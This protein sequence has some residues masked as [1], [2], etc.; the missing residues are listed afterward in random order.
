MEG[1]SLRS[2]TAPPTTASPIRLPPE[3]RIWTHRRPAPDTVQLSIILP[4]LQEEHV[5]PA[6]LAHFPETLR[7]K[8]G[9]ELIISDGGSTDATLQIAHSHADIVIQYTGTRRQSI[10]QGRNWGAFMAQGNILVFLNADS[11]PADPE[12][13]LWYIHRWAEEAPD[14]VA[15]ACPVYVHPAVAV[16]KDRAFHSLYNRYFALLNACGLGIGRGECHIVR[17]WAFERVGGYNEQL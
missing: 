11:V 4:T 10:A 9:A 8:H 1:V 16:W 15:L 7:G 2:Y 14:E 13:F 17:R 3:A 12:H 6:T 5:L